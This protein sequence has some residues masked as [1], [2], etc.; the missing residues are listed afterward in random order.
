MNIDKSVL[1]IRIKMLES[2][3]S[4]L[5]FKNDHLSDDNNKLREQIEKERCNKITF[6]D[7]FTVFLMIILAIVA[8][9]VAGILLIPQS[10]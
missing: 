8:I 7:I 4:I 1:E 10:I 9:Y 2:H 5:K 6:K 3:N